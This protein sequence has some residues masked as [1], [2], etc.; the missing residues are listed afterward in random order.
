MNDSVD[1]SRE[2]Q[3]ASIESSFGA[4]HGSSDELGT[5]RHPTKPRLR[6]VATYEVLPDADVWANA[7]DLFRFSERPGERGPELDDPRLDCAIMRPMESDGDHFLTY[8]LTKDDDSADQFKNSRADPRGVDALQEEEDATEF[9][10]VRDYEV[11]KVEQEVP[12]EFL[13]VFDE[14]ER[15]DIDYG[16]GDGDGSAG[17]VRPAGAYYKLI[18]RKMLLKKKRDRGTQ[19]SASATNGRSCASRTFRQAREEA[20][21]RAEAL[22]EVRDPMY[23]LQSA[24]AEGE[25]DIDGDADAD[26]DAEVVIPAP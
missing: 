22:A 24:D 6:A 13:L 5:L 4:A 7:Y 17:G 2:A 1:V 26:A 23:L 14:G 20:E 8:Y 15:S 16:D 3:L 11:V 19:S 10:F 12:N 9:H 25:D 21:E 18:E